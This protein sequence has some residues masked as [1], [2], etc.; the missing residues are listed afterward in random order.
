[1]T[2]VLFNSVTIVVSVITESLL[3]QLLQEWQWVFVDITKVAK[4]MFIV[5]LSSVLTV[6]I[7]STGD[8]VPFMVDLLRMLALGVADM[9]LLDL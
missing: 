1:M 4:Q 9:T 7:G 5:T 2:P 8:V 3:Q 6:S